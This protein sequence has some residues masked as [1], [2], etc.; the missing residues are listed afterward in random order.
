VFDDLVALVA[1]YR[2]GPMAFI[3]TYAKNK[4]RPS[5][6]TFDDP[7][8]EPITGPTYGVAIYQEQLM[9]ISRSIAGF[10]PSRA[11]DLRKA[12]GKKDKDLMASMK[13]EFVQ[14]CVAGGTPNDVAL[15]LWGLCEAAGDYSFNKSHAACYALLAYRTAWLKA[16]YPSE[17]MA[18]LLTSVM[19]TKDRVPFYVAAC[20]DMGISVLPPDVNVSG[21]E[22]EVTDDAD[23]RF[24]LTAVK[25]VG[26]AAV[27]AILEARGTGN[28]FTSLWDFCRRVNG[29]AVNKRALESLIRGGALDST[30]ASRAGMLENLEQAMKAASRARTDLAAGQESLFG[31][32][33]DT[34]AVGSVVLDPPI[35][36]EEFEKEDLLRYEKEALGLY[37][38]SHPLQDC[39][40]QLARAVTC[41][42]GQLGEKNDGSPVT[43]GGIVGAVKPITT[44]KGDQMLFVRIDDLEGSVE[45]VI[46]PAVFSESRDLLVADALVLISGRVDQKGEGETKVVAQAVRRFEPEAG[47]EE[48]KLRL[49][50]DAG[51]VAGDHLETLKQILSDHPGDAAVVLEMATND[52]PVR[53]R[54]GDDFKVDASDRSLAASLK[55]LFGERCIA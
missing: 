22:F 51:R 53:L 48:D 6:V 12:V 55:S 42:V 1:I 45:V 25:G 33:E 39:R 8:L 34:S 38:S 41:G 43:I 9:A 7:R 26:D 52:G 10:S 44:R 28:W 16:N 30:M 31:G 14:G 24:G 19:D 27:Q 50:V 11:D 35:L 23:I 47:G 36:T 2:P 15:R 54:F 20:S 37:V 18:A 29:A 46:V 13:E 21:A 17:Y 4:R 32:L 3:S 49:V 5:Q 40:R